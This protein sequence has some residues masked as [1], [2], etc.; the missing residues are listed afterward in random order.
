LAQ[1]QLDQI[2]VT[3]S[4]RAERAQESPSSVSVVGSSEIET[5]PASTLSDHLAA[6][7]GVDVA[8]TGMTTANVVVR[9]FNA[10]F[11]QGIRSLTDYR[12]NAYPGLEVSR[13][14]GIPVASE[15]I[16]R[17]EVVLGPAAALYGPNTANG[18]IQ[19][20]TKSPLTSTGNVV[21]VGGGDRG[22]RLGSFRTAH[23]IGENFGVKLSGSRFRGSEWQFTDTAEARLRAAAQVQLETFNASQRVLGRTDQQIADSIAHNPALS[24]LG[25]VGIRPGDVGRWGLDL[26]AD[27]R[28]TSDFTVVFQTGMTSTSSTDITGTGAATSD[29]FTSTYYQLRG[30]S[31]R[32]FAQAYMI[33]SGSGGT[34]TTRTG[35]LTIDHSKVFVAQLQHGLALFGGRQ[36]FTYGADV[37]HTLPVSE[38][39]TYGSNEDHDNITQGGA[40]AQSETRLTPRLRLV[41]GG[42]ADYN[43]ALKEGTFSPRVAFVYEPTHNHNFRA[44]YNRAFQ[45]PAAVALF[46]DRLSSRSGPYIVEALGNGNTGFNFRLPTGELALRSPFNGTPNSRVA[47]DKAA[48][49]RYAINFLAATGQITAT[50]AG[51]LLAANPNFTVFGRNAQ[52]GRSG[53]FDPASVADIPRL[54]NEISNAFELGYKGLVGERLQLGVDLW[55]LNRRNF[56][57]QLYAPAPLLL[58]SGTDL[59]TFLTA[60]GIPAAR[61]AALATSAA[62]VPMGAVAAAQTDI[63]TS[64]VPILITLKNYAEVDIRGADLSAHYSAGVLR[65]R[66][67]ASFV[68]DNYFDFG[69]AEQPIALNAPTKKA[70]LAVGYE[71]ADVMAEARVR[72]TG[73]FPVYS[74]VYTG[75]ACVVPAAQAVGA[76]VEP[77]TLLDFAGSAPLGRRGTSVQLSVTNVLDKRHQGFVDVPA[78]GRMALLQVRQEF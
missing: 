26:R 13:F 4:R 39:T 73:G 44:T 30:Y 75:N 50:E 64:G 62:S 23:R 43:S 15:D 12:T 35:D 9:G 68:S 38:G 47:Y 22:A 55:Q 71:S 65:V 19:V 29:G 60:N 78:V 51:A 37:I 61:A 2:V 52:T 5:R 25:R 24:A 46:L 31:G 33:Q 67:T 66:G 18:V 6:S 11:N 21:S 45:S 59:A 72:Y 36:D 27:W 56:M 63:Y 10:A 14:G 42:R 74:G 3:A 54:T 8:Q 40:Y 17:I 28:A 58:V 34:Y 16:D 20:L 53:V 76:C 48:V 41:L 57:S 7:P 77:A 49:S 69:A 70:S 1:S 32:L